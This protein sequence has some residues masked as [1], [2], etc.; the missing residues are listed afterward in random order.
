MNL[1]YVWI[2]K[3]DPS[4]IWLVPS[5]TSLCGRNIF[6]SLTADCAPYLPL[7]LL[8]VQIDVISSYKLILCC[9][10]VILLYSISVRKWWLID[11][12]SAIGT[13]Y[14]ELVLKWTYLV[15][16]FISSERIGQTF[17]MYQ[18]IQHIIRCFEAILY[19]F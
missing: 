4:F 18:H 2:T 6:I 9:I 5:A 8:S 14:L 11:F 15:S 17:K 16:I 13:Y 10:S 1:L 7:L 12:L 3:L 19:I